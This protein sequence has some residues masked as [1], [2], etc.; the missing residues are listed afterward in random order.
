MHCALL[1]FFNFNRIQNS[2]RSFD[3]FSSHQKLTIKPPPNVPLIFFLM[4]WLIVCALGKLNWIAS[5]KNWLRRMEIRSESGWIEEMVQRLQRIMRS[6][7][8]E[9]LKVRLGGRQPIWIC[10]YGNNNCCEEES[11]DGQGW[12]VLG[13][14][15]LRCVRFIRNVKRF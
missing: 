13:H 4:G 3:I 11:L 1:N 2:F 15:A 6:V 9:I 14:F 12:H 5:E 7:K 10:T 8:S